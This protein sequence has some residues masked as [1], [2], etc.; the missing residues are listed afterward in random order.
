M[1]KYFTAPDIFSRE[2]QNLQGSLILIHLGKKFLTLLN[3]FNTIL[4]IHLREKIPLFI[5]YSEN[6]PL[7]N[8]AHFFYSS[9]KSKFIY[10][11]F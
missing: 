1:P 8:S 4:N 5:F 9:R 7:L 3:K 11:V 6:I 2:L 10:H